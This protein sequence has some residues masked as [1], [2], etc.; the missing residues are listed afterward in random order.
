M[1]RKGFKSAQIIHMLGEVEIK[2]TSSGTVASVNTL[3]NIYLAAQNHNEVGDSDGNSIS[4]AS[5]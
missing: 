2:L 1:A 3:T 4:V 5:P